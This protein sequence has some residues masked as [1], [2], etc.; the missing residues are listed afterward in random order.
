MISGIKQVGKKVITKRGV[1]S[2]VYDRLNAKKIPGEHCRFCGKSSVPLIKTRCCETWICCDTKYM[3]ING[4]GRCQDMHEKY[5]LCHFHYNEK[6]KG[7]L[8]ECDECRKFVG[9]KK[10]LHEL[11]DPLNSPFF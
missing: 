6:H 4:G 10:F 9:D 3:S 2:L 5:S 11:K 8:N 1:N 7:P